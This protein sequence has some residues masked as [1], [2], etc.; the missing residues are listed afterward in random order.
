MNLKNKIIYS[1]FIYLI[2]K[3]G[4]VCYLIFSL[5]MYSRNPSH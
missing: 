1:Y 3:S 2:N 5:T 4:M